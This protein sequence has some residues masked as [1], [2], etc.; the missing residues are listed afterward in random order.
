[1]TPD[2]TAFN[3]F[4]GN[5]LLPIGVIGANATSVVLKKVKP[6]NGVPLDHLRKNGRLHEEPD[7]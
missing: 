4:I 3:N 7:F 5:R 1:M 6:Y 2:M